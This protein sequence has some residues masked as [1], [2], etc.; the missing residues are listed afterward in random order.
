MDHAIVF[1][2]MAEALSP[3]GILAIVNGDSPDEAEWH[4]E[5]LAFISQWINRI[6]GVYGDP[7][8]RAR[9]TGH[10]A[11][12]A[13]EG[14][15]SFTAVAHQPMDVFI[16]SEH[17]RATWARGKMGASLAALFD[18]E[19]RR[20]LAPYAKDGEIEYSVRTELMWGRPRTTPCDTDAS[21]TAL[22]ATGE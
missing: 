13:E 2:K 21:S 18:A 8:Y 14:K 12:I 11:W 17:S 16:E 9:V 22:P 4:D 6:G 1:P 5:Y 19:L 3:A 10:R 15:E 20:L 7:A